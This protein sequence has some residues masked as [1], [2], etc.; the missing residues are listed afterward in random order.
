[1]EL[2]IERK[3]EAVQGMEYMGENGDMELKKMMDAIFTR[4]ERDER[5]TE[6]LGSIESSSCCQGAPIE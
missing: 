3:K 5:K 1:M 2:G 6:C 4:A